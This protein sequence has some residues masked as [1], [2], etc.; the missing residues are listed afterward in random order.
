[1]RPFSSWPSSP[2]PCAIVCSFLGQH[3]WCR[4][5]REFLLHASWRRFVTLAIAP[6]MGVRTPRMPAAPSV[7]RSG[8]RLRRR[9]ERAHNAVYAWICKPIL[10]AGQAPGLRIHQ[11][12]PMTYRVQHQGSC[13][14]DR[15]PGDRRALWVDRGNRQAIVRALVRD[16]IRGGR[17]SVRGCLRSAPAERH[18]G[19]R[20][21]PLATLLGGG[22]KDSSSHPDSRRCLSMKQ[23]Q[24]GESSRQRHLARVGLSG[25]EP[26]TSAL[27]GRFRT[28][29]DAK[30]RQRVAVNSRPDKAQR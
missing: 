29:E 2:G 5:L 15:L 14:E 25:L 22:S 24:R 30:R 13:Y 8:R 20:T 12:A 26:L 27:S 18:S 17:K 7:D 23:H 1:L 3:E 16:S 6:M 19:R 21:T 4:A 10:A 9:V 11:L 28:P